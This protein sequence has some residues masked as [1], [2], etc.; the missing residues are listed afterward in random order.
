MYFAA[1]FDPPFSAFG[2][3][4]R[5]QLSR[6][7]TFGSDSSP[8]DLLNTHI[9]A[10]TGA[11]LTFDA[12]TARTVE[13]RV[14]ISYVGVDNARQ[15]LEAETSGKS[16]DV[17]RTDAR[18][19]WQHALGA[20]KVSGGPLDRTQRFYTAL[21]QA[22]IAP[23]V[24]SDADG[25]YM[26]M[27]GAV[28]T[29]QGYTQYTD[30]SG[31][32][33]YRSQV[34]LLAMLQPTRASSVARSFVADAEQSGWLPKWTVAN[35]Q[36]DV[37]TGDPADAIIASVRAFGA[38]GFDA[39][40][41]L[42][43]ML[44]GATRFGP[45]PH[46]GYE[47]RQALAA[48]LAFGYLPQDLQSDLPWGSAGTTLEYALDDFAIS[49]LAATLGDSR[50]CRVFLLRSGSWRNLYNR[51]SGYIEPR[52]ASGHFIP[53]YN[54]DYND[55]GSS[56][57]FAEGDSAQY[58]WM[59]PHDPAGLSAMIGGNAVAIRR[60]DIFFTQLNN[61]SSSPY[62][63]LG[64]EPSLGSPWLYDWFGQP[65]KTQQLVR[66]ALLTLYPDNP[67]GFP[68]NDD[69]GEMS[70]WYVLGAVGLYP[71]V[72]GSD[73]LALTSPL[74]PTIVVHTGGG[75]DIRVRATG[76]TPDGPYID[77]LRVDGHLSRRPW[78]RFR[79]LATGAT[80]DYV[81][82]AKPDPSWGGE[83]RDAPPS[84]GPS[85]MSACMSG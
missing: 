43:A 47:E 83:T 34:Q 2:T 14:G 85:D 60:L 35:A 22:L 32:D 81:L 20:I 55:W 42:K 11:Y 6:G 9:T 58:T 41:A 18:R 77:G 5:Q 53:R 33:I 26:G 30:F 13:M 74:F 68:G 21:Y 79:D 65:W 78:L 10:Q 29:A 8:G 27:D 51:A 19:A 17:L 56:Q 3:W 4:R 45:R 49:R 12:R 54:P 66:K 70:S 37:M 69:L 7:S 16:F 71:E 75:G 15:N 80:L 57:G 64:N 46:T 72:P 39:R 63:F 61:G 84:Y 23:T 52:L 24:F 1:Q 76:T 25:R 31:W 28:H 50:T 62:A 73:V 82:S 67:G 44:K 40:E 36:T 59:V 48:Y 38:R